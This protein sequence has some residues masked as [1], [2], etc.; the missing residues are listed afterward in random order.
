MKYREGAPVGNDDAIIQF[1]DNALNSVIVTKNA[2]DFGTH[3]TPSGK[4]ILRIPAFAF[5]YIL[6][7]IEKQTQLNIK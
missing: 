4:T 5:L 7:H 3:N 6:G 2:D 1:S